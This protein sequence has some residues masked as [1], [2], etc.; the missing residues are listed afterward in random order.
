MERNKN[1]IINRVVF[2]V[3]LIAASAATLKLFH[4]Q[5]L[6]NP[7]NYHS[8]VKA[9]ILE[10]QGLE[11]GYSFPYPVFF[12]LS[13]FMNLFAEP[14]L[15]VALAEML[16]N[17]LGLLITKIAF[18]R[19][20]L[21]ELEASVETRRSSLRAA[22]RRPILQS[23]MAG[24]AI[25]V[26]VVT[27]F[28]ISML[29]PPEG[30]Y[31]PGIKFLYLGVFTA[32]P[33]HN[34]TYM[35]AR[36]FAILAFLWFA[37]L[38]PV[39]EEGFA[40]RG[41][42]GS[43]AARGVPLRDYLLFSV[44]LL[45]TTM[46][47]PS[48]TIIL[49]CSAG[50]LMLYRLV[51]SGFRNFRPTLWLGL[52]FIPTFIEL[53]YQFKGVFVPEEAGEE[54]GIGFTLGEIWRGCCDNIPLAIGLA[55]GFPILVLLLN[56][57]E[58]KK[59]SLYRLS[60]INFC[61]GFATAFFLYEKGFRKPDF[62][63]AWGYMYGIFF[64]HM[65]ALLVLLKATAGLLAGTVPAGGAASEGLRSKRIR[66]VGVILQWLAYLWHVACGFYYFGMMMRGEIYI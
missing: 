3:L 54:G 19:L 11:S 14:E 51:R 41:T 59:N 56:Y 46:T 31:L 10:M 36:P 37:R 32:N 52:C 38:M 55:V 8:D 5:A 12:K 61:V 40:G 44:F 1:R 60:W 2:A 21:Q 53:L 20:A 42:G 66:A 16:L 35:A 50:L 43:G 26:V 29:F 45:L 23:W 65:G 17:S 15:A 28:F 4:L 39:Y 64:C 47:K 33:F 62:N 30:Y 58:L 34:A 18:D 25:S 22:G 6:G 13:A 48:Y 24:V 27:L 9:Y 7:E 63:F 49:V 57:R